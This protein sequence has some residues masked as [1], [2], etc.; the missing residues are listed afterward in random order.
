MIIHAAEVWLALFVA[1][2]VGSILGWLVY[3]W[4]D[5]SDYA[6]DQRELSKALGRRIHGQD[7]QIPADGDDLPEP[8]QLRL[9]P[10]PK[11]RA[12]ERLRVRVRSSALAAAWWKRRD[13]EAEIDLEPEPTRPEPARQAEPVARRAAAEPEIAPIERRESGP[14]RMP[15]GRSPMRP[16]AAQPDRVERI[17]SSPLDADPWPVLK[18]VW[19]TGRRGPSNAPALPPP[20]AFKPVFAE[21][22]AHDEI[23][24]DPPPKPP[25]NRR[26]FGGEEGIG[27]GR[28]ADPDVEAAANMLKPT[29][30]TNRPPALGDRP[31]K[32]D[33]LKRIKGIGPAFEKKLHQLGIYKFRQIA[34]W[35]PAERDWVSE[36]FGIAGRIEKDDWIGQAVELSEGR[37]PSPSAPDRDPPQA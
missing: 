13:P 5:R 30:E 27:S 12:A 17:E 22:P 11:S 9:P 14:I 1:F 24:S 23:W 6:F 7:A 31:A 10:P 36:A 15:P 26:I 19:P 32:P 18:P 2:A 4:I 37:N 21:K 28:S 25:S 29:D 8:G 34:S 20:S 33:N 16:A 3:R 35:T